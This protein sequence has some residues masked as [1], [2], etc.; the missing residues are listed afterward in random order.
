M[1]REK[2]VQVNNQI[3]GDGI[4]AIKL[5]IS[6]SLCSTRFSVEGRASG[7]GAENIRSKHSQQLA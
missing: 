4:A 5:E 1:R 3:F 6:W 2:R 7:H